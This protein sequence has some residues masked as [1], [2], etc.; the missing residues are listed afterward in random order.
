VRPENIIGDI[1]AITASLFALAYVL[2]M[3]RLVRATSRVVLLA[4]MVYMVVTRCVI[5][6]LELTPGDT[7]VE[8]HRSIIIV[9]QYILFAVAFGMTY[10]E[11]RDFRFGL[12]QDRRTG[13]SEYAG[14]D[15]RKP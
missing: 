4:A 6:A 10:Y 13:D 8:L 3:W 15:R 2:G 5:M 9:P 14:P 7:W 11:L 1:V 12:P